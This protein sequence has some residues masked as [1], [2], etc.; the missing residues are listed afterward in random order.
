M[1]PAAAVAAGESVPL[2]PPPHGERWQVHVAPTCCC[3]AAAAVLQ[4]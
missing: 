4:K 2:M 3:S 1:V